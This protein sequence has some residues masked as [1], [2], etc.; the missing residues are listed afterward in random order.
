[1]ISFDRAS[2]GRRRHGS[3]NGRVLVEVGLALQRGH[4]DSARRGR[5]VGWAGILHRLGLVLVFLG[6]CTAAAG[7]LIF[8][9]DAAAWAIVGRWQTTS[10]LS[11]F[12]PLAAHPFDFLDALKVG[13]WIQPIWLLMIALGAFLALFGSIVLKDGPLE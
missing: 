3:A 8:L 7:F 11:L 4:R 1:V 2:R 9:M 12:G 10:L 5:G 13:L 6:F